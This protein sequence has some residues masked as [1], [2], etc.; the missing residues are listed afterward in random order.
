MTGKGRREMIQREGYPN[1]Q[2]I[3][4]LTSFMMKKTLLRK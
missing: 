3:I 4:A 1:E 2:D